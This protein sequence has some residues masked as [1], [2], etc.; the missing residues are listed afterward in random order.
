MVGAAFRGYG[1]T[2]GT[3][4]VESAVNELAEILKISPIEIRMKNLVE[5]GKD[6]YIASGD[7]QKMY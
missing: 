2:Q 1:A 4:A 7:I 5:P 3:F 6:S